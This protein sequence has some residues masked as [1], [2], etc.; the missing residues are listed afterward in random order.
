M[1]LNGGVFAVA[2]LA[3]INTLIVDRCIFADDV[4]DS[5][6]VT[7]AGVADHLNRVIIGRELDLWRLYFGIGHGVTAS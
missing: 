6:L 7:H 2:A 3:L 5:V 4:D 1:Q